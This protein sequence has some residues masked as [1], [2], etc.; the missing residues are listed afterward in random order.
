METLDLQSDKKIRL[1]HLNCEGVEAMASIGEMRPDR[2]ICIVICEPPAPEDL[3]FV[4]PGSAAV[5]VIAISCC[6]SFL[7]PA[8]RSQYYVILESC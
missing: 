5:G 2:F 6:G 8:Q 3:R 1:W 7:L 4:R